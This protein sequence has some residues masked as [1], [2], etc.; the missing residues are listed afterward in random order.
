MR[1]APVVLLACQSAPAPAPP[2][3]PVLIPVAAAS[4]SAAP[5]VVILDAGA[6]EAAPREEPVREAIFPDA[7]AATVSLDALRDEELGPPPPYDH[8]CPRG[9]ACLVMR[10]VRYHVRMGLSPL[11]PDESRDPKDAFAVRMSLARALSAGRLCYERSFPS[12]DARATFMDAGAAPPGANGRI[13]VRIDREDGG[14]V[15]SILPAAPAI[16][17]CARQ[18]LR[19]VRFVGAATWFPIRFD[20]TWE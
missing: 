16:T 4:A 12:D 19:R 1:L 18:M 7:D 8:G 17:E 14:L 5:P 2:P 11:R 15:T 9:G 3:A 10:Q 6:P 13:L 20:M